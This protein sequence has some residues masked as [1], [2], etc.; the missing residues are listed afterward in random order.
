[1]LSAL[2]LTAVAA[3]SA[4]FVHDKMATDREL[5]TQ[6]L[7]QVAL[8]IAK[9]WQAK[10]VAGT[11]TREQAQAGAI[12]ALRPLRYGANDYFFVQ[13]YEGKTILNDTNRALEGKTRLD[14]TDPDGVPNVRLQ[15]DAAK[16]GGGFVYYRF[17]RADSKNPIQ[18]VSYAGGF[19]PW[20]WAICTGVYVDDIDAEYRAILLR[21]GLAA[22]GIIL[23]T[24]LITFL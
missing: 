20:Q 3:V 6:R 10:E 11:L 7:V 14:V 2:S 19:D 8:G 16:S 9:S 17:P 22:L 1:M 23:V 24:A 21:L 15:I 13:N 18:K 5:Q 4:S 12:E